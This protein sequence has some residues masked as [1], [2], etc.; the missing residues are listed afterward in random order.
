M[1]TTPSTTD[2][3]TLFPREYSC[4]IFFGPKCI[5]PHLSMLNAIDHLLA[6]SNR[7]SRSVC[8]CW[9]LAL[10]PTSLINLVSSANFSSMLDIPLSISSIYIMKSTDPKTD[11]WGTPLSTASNPKPYY[12]VPPFV[13]SG[14]A[15]SLPTL[16]FSLKFHISSIYNSILHATLCRK[17]FGSPNKPHRQGAYGKLWMLCLSIPIILSMYTRRFVKHDL[18]FL[19]PCW[20]SLIFSCFSKWSTIRSLSSM[21]RHHR[22][23]SL[24]KF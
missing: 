16:K 5:T 12:E 15:S 17:L 20:L 8:I 22:Q 6:H 19:K 10:E 14:W 21:E 3:R 1:C 24:I 7:L 11:P 23:K 18:L 2:L 4:L 9:E 13:V